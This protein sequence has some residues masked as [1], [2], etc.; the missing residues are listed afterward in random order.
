MELGKA[1]HGSADDR[2]LWNHQDGLH[3]AARAGQ[4]IRVLLRTRADGSRFA[5]HNRPP[6]ATRRP[7]T[8]RCARSFRSPR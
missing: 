4:P 5:V 7:A 8:W 1:P 3:V 2:Q 6:F